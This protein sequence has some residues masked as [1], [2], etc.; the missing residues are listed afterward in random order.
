MTAAIQNVPVCADYCNS[1]FEACKND[2]TCVEHWLEDFVVGIGHTA[3]KG[4][5][6]AVVTVS[7]VKD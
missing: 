4:H 3:I 2:S 1:W 7:G 6:C 5:H